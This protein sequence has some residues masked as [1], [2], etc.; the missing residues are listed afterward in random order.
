[1]SDKEETDNS[2][3]CTETGE[4][5]YSLSD[6]EINSQDHIQP[7]MFGHQHGSFSKESHSSEEQR[8]NNE[9]ALVDVLNKLET[10]GLK[11]HHKI[12]KSRLSHQPRN[13]LDET[14]RIR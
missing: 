3:S 9:T 13:K 14:T 1:M 6:L 4:S 5:D 11:I 8:D 2:N 10:T 12:S 7:F